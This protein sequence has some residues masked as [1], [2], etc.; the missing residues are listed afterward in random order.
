MTPGRKTLDQ[1]VGGAGQ[2]ARDRGAF[3]L[4]EVDR[5]GAAAAGEDIEVAGFAA[6]RRVRALD[7]DH[8]GAVVGQHHAGERAR[9]DAGDFDDAQAA[10]RAGHEVPFA[11]TAAGLPCFRRSNKAMNASQPRGSAACDRGSAAKNAVR[12]PRHNH[13]LEV[14]PIAADS[15][16]RFINRELSWLDFNHRVVDEADNARHPLLER[17]RFVS[18]SAANLDEFFSVR[19][20]GLVGQTRS[21]VGAPSPDGLTPAQQLSA[22]RE[23][24][25]VLLKRQQ[26]V[27]L[28]LKALLEGEGLAVVESAS[29]GEGERQWLDQ[30]FMERCFPC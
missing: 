29:L 24:A 13:K 28:E 6:G 21:G 11:C 14:P 18:I 19:V 12:P 3:G 16:D 26:G 30:W 7:A 23:A 5:D 27:W 20:A 9:A 15:P 25:L 22:V 1:A 8:F 17:L 2:V 10:Q 4:L